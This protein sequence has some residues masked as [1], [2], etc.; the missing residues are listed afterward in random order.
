M[1][2]KFA[3]IMNLVTYQNFVCR[4]LL[5]L[6]FIGI[7]HYVHYFAFVRSIH[8]LPNQFLGLVGQHLGGFPVEHMCLS[9]DGNYLI[10]SSQDSCHFWL[11]SQIPTL[12]GQESGGE[13]EEEEVVR[14]RKKRK[15]KQKH[16]AAEKLAKQ[17]KSSDFF[18]DL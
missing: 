5:I 9:H 11:V 16:V 15:R 18:S 10:T 1:I 12:P 17:K 14:R 2:V 7:I 8:V 6:D 4:M 13:E 3:C